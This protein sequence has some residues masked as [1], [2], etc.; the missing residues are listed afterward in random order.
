MSCRAGAARTVAMIRSSPLV[1]GWDVPGI[2]D[3]DQKL[4]SMRRFSGTATPDL[5]A[6]HFGATLSISNVLKNWRTGISKPSRPGAQ[7]KPLF[8]K[9]LKAA[10]SNQTFDEFC[11]STYE[12]FIN[13]LPSEVR[14]QFDPKARI[15]DRICIY[16]DPAHHTLDVEDEWHDSS[17]VD[18]RFM[19]ISRFA[20]SNWNKLTEYGNYKTYN[21]CEDVLKETLSTGDFD[22][23]DVVVILGAGSYTKDRKIVERFSI[24]SSASKPLRIIIIDASFYMLID[25]YQQMRQY[26]GINELKCT[27]EMY[28]FDFA[29]IEAWKTNVSIEKSS[30]VGYFLLGGTIGNLREVDFFSV[31]RDQIDCN[32]VL[33]VAG[34]F[35]DS[36]EE[37]HENGSRIIQRYNQDSAKDLA[38]GAVNDILNMEKNTK[39][40]AERREF[41]SVTLEN[42]TRLR[43][44]INSSVPGTMAVCFETKGKIETPRR[45]FQK[46][47]LVTSKRYVRS[48]FISSMKSLCDL[49]M[50]HSVDHR[51]E[52]FSHLVF[53]K[54]VF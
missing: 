19:Y 13:R 42:A 48:N 39:S 29:E 16:I 5:M 40:I 26:I 52:R 25:T 46:L 38:L 7:H 20:T 8:E 27:V 33:I 45:T 36:E 9:M 14:A 17:I 51:T 54:A 6:A 32:D 15:D 30:S 47:S 10:R 1:G 22:E 2:V 4:E 24:S 41:V 28:C 37:I 11:E 44:S 31:L 49:D 34:E 3:L 12:G 50:V 21:Y 35:F 18:Q 43:G 23:I 53:K